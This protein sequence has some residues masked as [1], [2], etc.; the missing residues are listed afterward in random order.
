[1]RAD[2]KYLIACDTHPEHYYQKERLPAIKAAL[3]DK[4][5]T[6][7]DIFG[8]GN[9]EKGRELENLN[10]TQTLDFFDK[11]DLERINTKFY[12]RVMSY[13]FDILCLFTMSNYHRF[14]FPDTINKIRKSGVYVVGFFG[15]DEFNFEHNKYWLPLFDNVVAY[16]KTEIKKYNYLYSNV[17]HLPVGAHFDKN[18]TFKKTPE[19]EKI[20]DVLFVGRP[21]GSRER[22]IEHL[23]DNGINVAVF[24]SERWARNKK[25]RP[26]YHGFLL[27]KKYD[28]TVSKAKILIG[29]MEDDITGKPH[30]NAK[31][32][33]AA[34]TKQFII[35]TY[36][37]PFER[38]YGFEEGRH[39]VMYKSIKELVDKIKY[40]LERPEERK[41]IADNL[42]KK[43]KEEYNYELLYIKLFNELEDEYSNKENELSK[44]NVTIVIPLK[45]NKNPKN[46]DELNAVYVTKNK[47]WA[48][49]KIYH[50][51]EFKKNYDKIIKTDY[52]I[53]GD[54]S[55]TYSNFLDEYID[56]LDRNLSFE[57]AI[58]DS[59]SAKRNFKKKFIYDV[60]SVIWKK[61]AF[62]K[63]IL[64][65]MFSKNFV[66]DLDQKYMHIPL[67]FNKF[68]NNKSTLIIDLIYSVGKPIYSIARYMGTKKRF[69]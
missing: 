43:V 7:I 33:D 1:M 44:G 14:L 64:N 20:Y 55:V 39:V 59:I 41:V 15:D 4:D 8:F 54:Y 32:F 6:I 36:Y 28:E 53:L 11:A 17:R 45:R 50:Y 23:I 5:Y 22:N 51:K 62:K 69:K 67:Y 31:L 60:Y 30:I 18:T 46:M 37:P 56:F 16:T 40:Y 27:N 58:F 12:E 3:K 42:H 24:G 66:I 9:D 61:E 21:Y 29:F 10:S 57:K 38:D 13:D 47:K 48:D 65:K 34:K 52:A 63:D 2:F 49:D 35:T 68:E 26:Y 19:R 25:I